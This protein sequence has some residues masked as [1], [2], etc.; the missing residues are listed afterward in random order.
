M[1][2]LAANPGFSRVV[3]FHMHFDVIGALAAIAVLYEY[4]AETAG[5]AV[6]PAW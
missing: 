5:A 4:G 3:P 2:L 1:I 6:R